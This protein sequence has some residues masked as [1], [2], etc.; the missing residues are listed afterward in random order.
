MKEQFKTVKF[1]STT[2]N[3]ISQANE[4]IAEYENQGFDLTLRQLYYQFVSKDFI[5]NTEKSYKNLGSIINNGRLA[6]MI[7]WM[8]IEDRTRNL[9]GNSHWDN[10][11]EI[12]KTCARSFKIDKWFNQKNYVEVWIE[13]DALIG[14]ISGVC[15][16]MDVNYFSCRGYVSQS[17]M[18]RAARRFKYKINEG[19]SGYLIHLGDHDPSGIDMTRDIGDRL[20][21]FGAAVVVSRVALNMPQIEDLNPP[22]NP[23]KVTDSRYHT[24]QREYGEESYELDALFPAYITDLIKE[25]IKIYRSASRWKEAVTIEN[26]YKDRLEDLSENWEVTNG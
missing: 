12:I 5:P 15:E 24:Y 16:K 23:A 22:P 7:D 18:W 4:I 26:K 10:P 13:K 21:T 2:L 20:L 17:E 3:I 11:G 14:V 6:G 1:K 8:A 19:K 9:R 25:S